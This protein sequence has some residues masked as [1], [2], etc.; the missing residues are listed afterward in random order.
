[1]RKKRE[2]QLQRVSGTHPPQQENLQVYNEVSSV[3]REPEARRL[4][5]REQNADREINLAG[6]VLGWRR[7]QLDAARAEHEIERALLL[8]HEVRD[9]AMK[10]RDQQAKKHAD[11]ALNDVLKHYGGFFLM[12]P[13]TAIR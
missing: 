12:M 4:K 11:R 10:D 6:G 9:W 2:A 1:M 5:Q 13:R 7:R 3:D 8:Q